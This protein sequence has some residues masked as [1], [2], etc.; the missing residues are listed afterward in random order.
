MYE[1]VRM[2]VCVVDIYSMVR[3]IG[4]YI[5]KDHLLALQMKTRGTTI[6][7]QQ[8]ATFLTGIA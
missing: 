6:T 8:V 5:Y 3:V 7:A 2:C 4:Q 1:R